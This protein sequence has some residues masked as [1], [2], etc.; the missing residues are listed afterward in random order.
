MAHFVHK[1]AVKHKKPKQP[2]DYLVRFFM[3]ATPLFEIPQALSI[4]G[5]KDASGVSG[6]TWIFFA[7]SS[8]VWLVYGWREKIKPLVVAYSL[9]LT[10]ETSIVIG[11][12]M[13]S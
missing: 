5:S 9:Y 12:I 6:I 1:R 2:I 8:A 3:I 4:Y 11:I 10:I 13:Y 7:C